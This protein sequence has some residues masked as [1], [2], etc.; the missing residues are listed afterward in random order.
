MKKTLIVLSLLAAL[1][2][3]ACDKKD[4]DGAKEEVAADVGSQ[5]Q[6][7]LDK[8]EFTD[9]ALLG[10]IADKTAVSE[11]EYEALIRAIEKCDVDEKKLELIYDC[12]ALKALRTFNN[13]KNDKVKEYVMASGVSVDDIRAKFMKSEMHKIQAW[14]IPQTSTF[15]GVNEDNTSSLLDVEKTANSPL[16]TKAVINTLSNEMAKKAVGDF[17]LSNVDNEHPNIRLAVSRAVGSSWSKKV[18]GIVDVALNFLNDEDLDVRKSACSGLGKLE[19]EKVIVPI[20][21]I[22]NDKAKQDLHYDCLKSLY[23][24]WYDYP[25]HVKT[26]ENA[27]KATLDY[28]KQTPRTETLPPWTSVGALRSINKSEIEAWKAKATYFK[29][30]EYIA[31]MSDIA[32]DGNANWIG[33]TSAVD[34]IAAWGTKKDLEALK[35]KLAS[36]ASSNTSH[37]IR[38]VDEALKAIETAAAK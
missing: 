20:V 2:I 21:E 4:K 33:R 28:L 30:D 16:V 10:M 1:G 13:A 25:F 11:I 6:A 12:P 24:L 38:T 26:S 27:Y 17:I 3:N 37:V 29:T 9:V 22:L 19:D 35:S 32:V 23:D 36:D 7:L 15:F 14:L 18:D 5:A 31:L 8:A 34:V